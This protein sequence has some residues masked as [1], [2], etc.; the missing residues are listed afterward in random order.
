MSNTALKAKKCAWRH[1]RGVSDADL[2]FLRSRYAFHPLD[3]EDIRSD[4]PIPKMD[5]YPAYVFFIFHVPAFDEN[6]YVHGRELF[7]FLGADSLV[8]ISKHPIDAIDRLAERAEAQADV[9]GPLT[10]KGP[11]FLMYKLLH[12][13]FHDAK[14]IVSHI[15]KDV[16]RLEREIQGGSG[17]RT[18]VELGRARRN[19]LFTRHV[20]DPQRHMLTTLAGLKR[21][22][23]PAGF[24]V[25][26]DDLQDILDTMSL[27]SENLKALIDGLFDVNEALQSHRTNTIITLLTVVSAS[28]MAPTLVAGFYGMNVPWLPYVDAPPVIGFVYA[29]ALLVIAAAILLIVRSHKE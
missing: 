23:L 7:M 21:P 26:I 13:T 15:V 19:V 22:F 9:R 1:F 5:P 6:G 29:A 20:I 12:Q 24:D 14:P 2:E 8:T 25:Y 11:A 16:A 10:G 4:N 3:F 28:L 27:T 17:R 18:T